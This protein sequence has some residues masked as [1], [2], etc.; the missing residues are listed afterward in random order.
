MSKE[1]CECKDMPECDKCKDA[2]EYKEFHKYKSH[3]DD[4]E[5]ECDK[6]AA[7]YDIGS[8]DN[9]CGNCGN[10]GSCCTHKG[11]SNA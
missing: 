2:W 5:G 11:E 7:T 9:R 4:Q 6:C 1:L 10:C 3:P 8:Q